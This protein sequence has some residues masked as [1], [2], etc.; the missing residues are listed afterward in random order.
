[1]AT[2]HPVN[3]EWIAT[4]FSKG[5]EAERALEA[6]AKATV[7]LAPRPLARRPLPRDRR[8][9]RPAPPDRRD[10][11]HPLRL[12]PVREATRAGS[13]ARSST[14][15]R[16]SARWARPPAADRAR[17]LGQGQ[18]DPLVHR[19][20]PHLPGHRRR[21][22]R[23]RTRRRPDRGEGPPRRPPG[24]A[25]SAASPGRPSARSDRHRDAQPASG[26]KRVRLSR[27]GD[28]ARRE[29]ERMASLIRPA[30]PAHQA[31]AWQHF[32]YFFPEPQGQGS[33]RPTRR[34]VGRLAD[35]DAL[36]PPVR[37]EPLAIGPADHPDLGR[38]VGPFADP[39]AL[40]E[41]FE[42]PGDDLGDMGPGVV[43]QARAGA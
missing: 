9:R 19:L 17:P 15:G 42:E 43:G 12:Q 37:L 14:S 38:P 5:I 22:E 26:R 8:R 34:G 28:A 4:E 1:M 39:A 29:P 2:A 13:A 6:D 7:R 40:L 27:C 36:D 25:Q 35:R 41:I 32:L 20:G 16:R 3:R 23:P 10:H 21:R 24:G 33:F 11:R 31:R 30:S 18:R